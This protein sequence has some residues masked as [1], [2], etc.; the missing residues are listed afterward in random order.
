MKASVANRGWKDSFRAEDLRD[1][2]KALALDEGTRDEGLKDN[3][4]S[5]APQT[6]ESCA[7]ACRE[8]AFDIQ[9]PRPVVSSARSLHMIRDWSWAMKRIEALQLVYF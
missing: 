3:G 2:L 9:C 5:F 6:K 1:I 4:F 8:N 7:G